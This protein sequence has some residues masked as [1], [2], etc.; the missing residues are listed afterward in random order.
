[1][2][3]I[4]TL[5]AISMHCR[6]SHVAALFVVG[7]FAAA[8][9]EEELDNLLVAIHQAE[10][11]LAPDGHLAAYAERWGRLPDRANG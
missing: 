7:W 3:R 10:R 6:S 4:D 11:E 2:Q 1:M 5:R 9:P 8:A